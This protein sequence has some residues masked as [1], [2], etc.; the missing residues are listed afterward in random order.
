MFFQW[1]YNGPK[2]H[3][4]STWP[5]LTIFHLGY[6]FSKK[7]SLPFCL[8]I[9][10]FTTILNYLLE[11]FVDGEMTP[12]GEDTHRKLGADVYVNNVERFCC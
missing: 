1:D 11:T 8:V 7:S 12:A 3:W 2:Q 9:V 4:G 5:F 10:L 6:T